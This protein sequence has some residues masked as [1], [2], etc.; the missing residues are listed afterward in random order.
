MKKQSLRFS[1]IATPLIIVCGLMIPE[2][3]AS[4]QSENG[5]CS[6]RMLQGDYGFAVEGVVLPAPGVQLPVR[7]VAMTHFDGEGHLSQVDHIVINGAPPEL[8]WTPG[9]GTYHVNP[10]CTGTMR[11]DIPSARDF[12]NLR[13]VVVMRG[14]EIHTV[15]TAPYNG[16]ARTVTS[17]GIR[18]D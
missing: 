12:V 7:G 14:Q 13:F 8:E 16:P 1:M 4:A 6:D 10:D 9:K 18:R 15:V 17:V 2:S 11:I 3:L 5:Q